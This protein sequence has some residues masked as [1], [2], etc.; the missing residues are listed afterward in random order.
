M[1]RVL[2]LSSSLFSFPSLFSPI[3]QLS[4]LSRKVD[5]VSVLGLGGGLG[6]VGLGFSLLSSIAE[7]R[8]LVIE[9]L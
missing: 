9:A 6:A 2:A 7:L 1:R 4:S 5:V 3:F 8:A